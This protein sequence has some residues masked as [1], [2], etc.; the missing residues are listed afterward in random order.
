LKAPSSGHL[1]PQP[2]AEALEKAFGGSI[3][4]PKP[5]SIA[6]QACATS[7]RP[8]RRHTPPLCSPDAPHAPAPRHISAYRTRWRLQHCRAS[9]IRPQTRMQC[10][11]RLADD[12]HAHA[13]KACSR[14]PRSCEATWASAAVRSPARCH[15]GTALVHSIKS[16]VWFVSEAASRLRVEVGV[17]ADNVQSLGLRATREALSSRRV[18]ATG[19]R[20]LGGSM[21]R[22]VAR[23]ARAAHLVARVT[24]RVATRSSR[25]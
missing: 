3:D 4:P 14:I 19:G 24:T 2:C 17:A 5:T 16:F 13:N 6:C 1:G 9:P 10:S 25:L 22:G 11:A 15:A 12:R 7:C 20:R 23:A 18:N 21:S 8:R